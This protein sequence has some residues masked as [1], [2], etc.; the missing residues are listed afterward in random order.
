[1][2]KFGLKAKQSIKTA[3]IFLVHKQDN[4]RSVH[5][6]SLKNYA[7]NLAYFSW[8]LTSPGVRFWDGALLQ[9][10]EQQG[11]ENQKSNYWA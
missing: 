2:A 7:S 9:M 6:L 4:G 3:I 10:P 5:R 1:M 8:Y 11:N